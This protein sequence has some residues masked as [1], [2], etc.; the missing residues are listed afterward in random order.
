MNFCSSHFIYFLC[1]RLTQSDNKNNDNHCLVEAISANIMLL[2]VVIFGK[3]ERNS[4]LK[5][6][7]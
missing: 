3:L 7:D 6:L 1:P 5:Y 2:G 4:P